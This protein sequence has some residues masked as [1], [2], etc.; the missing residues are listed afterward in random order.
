M[1]RTITVGLDGSPESRAAAEWA[2]REAVLR[3]LPV[4][5]L[6]VPH[7]VP[8]PM[9]QAPLLGAETLQ[10]WS[11]RIPRESAEGLRLR[12]PAV[13]VRTEQRPGAP[14]DVLV[15]AAAEADL[16]VLGS[17]ALSG[18]GGFLVGSVGQ[19]VVARAEAPVVLV[20]TG[21]QAADE[22]VMDAT[23][24]PSATTA[25]RPVVVGVDLARPAE[26]P[27]AFALDEA[28][29]RGTGL[30]VVHGWNLSPYYAYSLAAGVDASDEAARQQAAELTGLLHPWRQKYPDV[31]V[32]E[33]S[34]LG[35]PARQL[36]EA[37][38]DASLV[39]VGRRRRRRPF[40]IHIG[41]VAHAVMHHSTVPVAVVAHE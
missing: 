22:H 5:L 12:H 31:P 21:T 10:H 28:R 29:R 35:S 9:A 40:G 17:R 27:L 25:F 15:E 34:R 7:P 26:A 39:V 4:T 23:G 11:E 33:V 37:A 24:I 8:D 41:S 32:T 6:H 18:L 16:L 13:E 20:R 38:R 19:A 30:Y 2:A 14:V 36:I 3:D 1:P